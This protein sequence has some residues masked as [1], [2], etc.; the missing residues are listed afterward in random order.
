MLYLFPALVNGSVCT[1]FQSLVN[2]RSWA[3]YGVPSHCSGGRY[4]VCG[5]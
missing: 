1:D 2:A 3:G 4:V 5:L